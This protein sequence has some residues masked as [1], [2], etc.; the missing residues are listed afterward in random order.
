[1]DGAVDQIFV[2]CSDK[3]AIESGLREYVA[4]YGNKFIPCSS[5]HLAGKQQVLNALV[6]KKREFR[7]LSDRGWTTVWEAVAGID[8]ADASVAKFLSTR[9]Q[10]EAILV[11]YGYDYNIW[12]FMIF[13]CGKLVSESFLPKSYFDGFPESD[14]RFDYG[15]CIDAAN[16]FNRDRSLP[17]FLERLVSI[18][19]NSKLA[20]NLLKVICKLP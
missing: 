17:F 13:D 5:T 14:N 20:R 3:S 4:E 8:F 10:A 15:S 11:L 2:K 7:L 12:A 16:E 19:R 1:M 9:L 6:R 18:E